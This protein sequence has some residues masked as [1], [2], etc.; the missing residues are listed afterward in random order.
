MMH[1][2]GKHVCDAMQK[3]LSTFKNM[4]GV[5][6]YDGTQRIASIPGDLH[7]LHSHCTPLGLLARSPISHHCSLTWCQH[8]EHF[9]RLWQILQMLLSECPEKVLCSKGLALTHL[10]L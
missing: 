6:G 10:L 4:D 8:V 3:L 9:G 7:L 1:G 5:Q 2:D